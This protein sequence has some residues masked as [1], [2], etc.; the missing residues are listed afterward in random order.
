M[1]AI[2]SI[3]AFHTPEHL[4]EHEIARGS[5]ATL[6]RSRQ[7]VLLLGAGISNDL[8][9]PEWSGLVTRVAKELGDPKD[10]SSVRSAGE[11][12]DAIDQMRRKSGS[13]SEQMMATVRSA[14][15]GA[16][17]AQSSP[18][19]SLDV[20]DSRLLTALGALMMASARG[21]AGEVFTLNFDDIL[22]WYLDL[23]G[24]SSEIVCE[25][26]QTL[27]GDVDVHVFH[28]H[29]F[30]PL[31]KDRYQ[32][33]SWMILSKRQL[34]ERLARNLTHAWETLLLNRLQS[35]VFLIVGTSM[36]DTD[37][38]VSLARARDSGVDHPLGFVLGVHSEDKIAELREL[39]MVP[40]TF[41]NHA[42]IASFLLEVCQM[43]AYL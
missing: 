1:S 18:R 33:S 6:L 39:N 43:A 34:E 42:E 22:E 37:V 36:S 9:L 3:W 26:P 28:I 30:L 8:G 29:G 19:H 11:L 21:S 17:A 4:S 16:A 7:L 5:L 13:S 31:M 24:F 23:H 32:T 27:R 12:M 10:Y 25:L 2:D 40:V 20:I 14:L 41:A 15:Y 35:K 38:R